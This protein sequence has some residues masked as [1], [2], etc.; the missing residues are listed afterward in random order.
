MSWP[1]RDLSRGWWIIKLGLINV[2][3]KCGV[4]A[5]VVLG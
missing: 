4:I 3:N 5:L 1:C 2:D